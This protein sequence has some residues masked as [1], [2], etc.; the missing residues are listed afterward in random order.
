MLAEIG[1]LDPDA[2]AQVRERAWPDVHDAD[3]L[4]EALQVLVALP[5]NFKP[6]PGEP[7]AS[8]WGDFMRRL[9]TQR[10][11]VIH[12]CFFVLA[13]AYRRGIVALRVGY[14]VFLRNRLTPGT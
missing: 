2:I 12:T 5:E 3:E 11:L 10:S 7:V 13:F 8:R 9:A 4:S 6:P 1:H 14:S